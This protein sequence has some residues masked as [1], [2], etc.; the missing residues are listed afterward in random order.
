MVKFTNDIYNLYSPAFLNANGRLISVMCR[1]AAGH[2][3]GYI[4]LV[5]SI[6]GDEGKSWSKLK[7]IAVPP[8]RHVNDDINNT[9]TAFFLQPSLVQAEN[10]DIILITAFLPESRG[11]GDMSFLEKKKAAFALFDSQQCQVIYDKDG[12]YFLVL[13]DGKVID[14]HKRLTPYRVKQLGELYKDKEYVGN[15]F[16][17]G[18][19]GKEGRVSTTFGA[20]LKAP[21]RSYIYVMISKDSGE[22]WSEPKDISASVLTEKDGPYVITASGNS[23]ITHTG[24]IIVPLYSPEGTI[25]IYSDDNGE[26]WGRNRRAPYTECGDFWSIANVGSRQLYAVG[27]NG[28]KTPSALSNDNGITWYKADKVGFKAFTS[29][30]SI[31]SANNKLYVSHACRKDLSGQVSVGM[32]DFDRHGKISRINWKD[33]SIKFC[34]GEIG[35]SCLALINRSTLGIMYENDKTVVFDKI[36]LSED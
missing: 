17:N 13:N 22:T 6:S 36:N 7:P 18:A 35:E 9:R 33:D 34:S 24:R 21:K 4:E 1:A 16:L 14:A 2:D 19:K 32:L 10:G 20:P 23:L 12:N 31:I 25:C 15:I 5:S 26:S 11:K 3:W 29:K 28:N 8:A 30:K 27:N